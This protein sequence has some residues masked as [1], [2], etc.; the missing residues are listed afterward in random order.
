MK[1]KDLLFV[2]VIGVAVGILA[3]PVLLNVIRD[4]HEVISAPFGVIRTT[5]FIFFLVLAPFALSMASLIG[6]KIPVL[7]Q[8]AKFAAVGSLNS[9]VDLG[10]FNLGTY[11]YGVDPELLSNTAFFLFKSLSFLVATTNSYLWNKR[12]TFGDTSTSHA[13][14]IVK[15]YI[16]T[17]SIYFLNTG[18]ATLVKTNGPLFGISPN[19]WVNVL[20]PVAGIFSAM[21]VNFL[22]YKFFVFKKPNAPSSPEIPPSS[23]L[24]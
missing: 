3:Q 10:I 22:S 24:R 23:R 21:L 4:I 5:V 7:Y 11:L 18:M 17:G 12:W 15:F 2:S 13:D 1:K 8:F 9:F 20:S 14:T 16:I 19:L 6:K